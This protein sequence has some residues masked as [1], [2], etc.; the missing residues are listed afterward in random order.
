VADEAHRDVGLVGL[1]FDP[2]QL[3]RSPRYTPLSCAT[4]AHG[5]CWCP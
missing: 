3:R 1:A 4:N 5:S 2:D